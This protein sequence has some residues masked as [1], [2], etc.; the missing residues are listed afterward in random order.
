MGESNSGEDVR[1]DDEDDDDYIRMPNNNQSDSS[2]SIT[3]NNNYVN[4]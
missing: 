3:F 4:Y 2:Q 1:V